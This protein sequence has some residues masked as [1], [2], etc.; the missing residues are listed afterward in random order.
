MQSLNGLVT[1]YHRFGR[2]FCTIPA[3]IIDYMK[4]GNFVWTKYACASFKFIKEKLSGVPV[5][6]LPD[7]DKLIEVDCDGSH[8]GIGSVLK[9]SD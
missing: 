5:L 9:F 1:F 3:P 2:N 4:K 8:V 7:F 6:A